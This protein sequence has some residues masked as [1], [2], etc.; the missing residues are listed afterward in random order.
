M[1]ILP[2]ICIYTHAGASDHI[3]GK[4]LDA[5]QRKDLNRGRAYLLD[6]AGRAQQRARELARKAKEERKGREERKERR[7]QMA[8]R[9]T[10][11]AGIP[12][13]IPSQSHNAWHNSSSHSKEQTEEGKTL[14]HVR[15]L[16]HVMRRELYFI[17]PHLCEL[18]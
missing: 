2:Q 4:A 12:G 6:V 13:P 14:L 9:S 18:S 3:T 5:A 7:R 8:R 17:H 1:R 16:I 10:T 11:G 15:V